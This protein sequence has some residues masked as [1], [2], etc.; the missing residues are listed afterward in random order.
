MSVTVIAAP[1]MAPPVGSVISPEI[2]PATVCASIE[3]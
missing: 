2:D 1:A 3:T